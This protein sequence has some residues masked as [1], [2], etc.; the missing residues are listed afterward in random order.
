MESTNLNVNPY[1]DDYDPN[2]N[3]VRTLFRP[4]VAVQARE[5]TQLQTALQAQIERFGDSILKQGSVV[6]GMETYVDNSVQFVKLF[7]TANAVATNVYSFANTNIEGVSSGVQAFVVKVHDGAQANT[8]NLKTL[9]LKY[10]GTGNDGTTRKFV[11]GERIRSSANASLIAN[12]FIG[13]TATGNSSMVTVGNGVFYAHGFFIRVPRQQLIISKYDN[14]AT[15]SIG[16]YI[17]ETIVDADDDATLTDPAQGEYNYTAPGANRLKIEAILTARD[18]DS[19][20][21]SAYFELARVAN[22]TLITNVRPKYSEIR[23]ELARRTYDESGDYTVK[24][25]NVLISEHLNANNN[26]GIFTAAQG[27]NYQKFV[28]GVQPGKAYIR[29]YELETLV[30]DNL[31]LDKGIDTVDLTSQII[32]ANFGNYTYVKRVAGEWDTDNLLTVSLHSTVINATSSLFSSN[33]AA[34]SGVIG[35]ARVRSVQYDSG[36]P[37]GSGQDQYKMFLF[38]IK[39]TGSNKSFADV[40]SLS[41]T[42]GTARGF[43]DCVLSSGR[44]VL[45]DTNFNTGLFPL[46]QNAIRRLRSSNGAINTTIAYRNSSSV[47]ISTGGTFTLTLSGETFNVGAGTLTS[48]QKTT[49]FYVVTTANGTTTLTG[50]IAAAVSNT[51]TGTG[52]LFDRQ[53]RVGDKILFGTNNY[54]RKIT[55]IASNTSLTISPGMTITKSGLTFKRV[56]PKGQV[57][58]YNYT[59]SNPS[60]KV[61][62]IVINSSTSATFDLKETPDAT[63][64]AKVYYTASKTAAREILKTAY[65]SRYIRIKCST[66]GATNVGPWSLGVSDVFSIDEVRKFTTAPASLTGGTVVTSHFDLDNGQR[67][68]VYENARLVK[69]GDSNLSIGASDWLLVKFSFFAPD[70]SQGF[71]YFSVDSYPIDDVHTSNTSAIQTSLIPIYQSPTTGLKYDLRNALDMRPVFTSTANNVTSLTNISTNPANSQTITISTSARVLIPNY[72]IVADLSYYL[73]RIDKIFM[74]TDGQFMVVRGVPSLLPQEPAN[75]AQALPIATV[76]IPPYPS[77]SPAVA[78]QIGNYTYAIQAQAIN[79][80]RFTMKDIASLKARINQLEYYT[81]LTLLELSALDKQFLNNS[82]VD[83]FKNGIFVEQFTGHNKD[84]FLLPEYKASI[85]TL[86]QVMRPQYDIA[87][88]ALDYSAS[89]SSGVVNRASDA[90]LVITGGSG[91]FANGETIS[92]SGGATGTVRYNVNNT[93]LYVEDVTGTFAAAQTLTG[94]TSGASKTISS[95]TLPT[96]SDIFTLPYSHKLLIS[97]PYA[98]KARN[99]AG[100]FYYLFKGSVAITPESDTWYDTNYQPDINTRVE[101]NLAGYTLPNNTITYGDWVTAWV[102]TPTTSQVGAA[103][104]SSDPTSAWAYSLN[105]SQ[106]TEIRQARVNLVG[107]WSIEDVTQLVDDHVI[108]TAVIP[109]MRSQI[110]QIQATALRPNTRHYV[111]FD[112][113]NVNAYVKP[114]NSSF[115]ATGSAGATLTTDDAGSLYALFTIPATDALRFRTGSIKLRLTDGANTASSVTS[116]GE[117]FYT[118]MGSLETRQRTLVTTRQPYYREQQVIEYRTI[119]ETKNFTSAGFGLK[120][121]TTANPTTDINGNPTDYV[122][123]VCPSGADPIAQSFIVKG[124]DGGVFITKI[125][126]FFKNKSSNLPVSVELRE[127][128]NGYPGTKVVSQAVATVFP[129]NV[130]TS[131]NGSLPT[132]FVFPSPVYLLNDVEY[133]FVVKPGANNPD[134]DIWVSE[135]G[136]NDLV[137]GVTIAQQPYT[138]ILFT[139]SNDSTWT[140]QQAE[141]IKFKLYVAEFDTNTTGTLLMKNETANYFNVTNVSSTFSGFE[142]VDGEVRLTL[143]ATSNG[144][145][146]I[147]ASVLGLT[148]RATGILTANTGALGVAGSTYRIR[149]VGANVKF[150]TSER[151]RF[152]SGAIANLTSQTTPKGLAKFYRALPANTQ[153]HL[154]NTTGTFVTGEQL[155]GQVSG[156]KAFISS[157]DNLLM[158]TLFLNI[159]DLK[160]GNTS[161]GYSVKTTNLTA[162]GSTYQTLNNRNNNDFITEEKRVWSKKN[163]VTS[164]SGAKSLTVRGQLSSVNP[165]VSPV[166]D[167]ERASAYVVGNVINNDSTNETNAG[168]GSAKVRYITRQVTLDDGQDAD[169]LK[170]LLTAF[171]PPTSSILVY[172]KILNGQDDTPFDQAPYIL[173]SQTSSSTVYSDSQSPTDVKEYE[174]GFASANLT[175]TNGEVQYTN[176]RGAKFTG[177]KVFALKIVLLNSV[178]YNPPFVKDIRAIALQT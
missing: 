169:D 28:A 106:T 153:I 139:S 5:L 110:I 43:A 113:I 7:N 160:F 49:N 131:D 70:Y 50:T 55:N 75:I 30:T 95:V 94:G 161:L 11:P 34:Y 48:D 127:M 10:T 23:E 108:S 109:Y 66:H 69:K 85:D 90:T 130:N 67:D 44:A 102:G 148:S 59:A 53:L 97:Q 114:A 19:A 87:E 42:N 47:T 25:F 120:N 118:A 140:A 149:D 45:N 157:I 174:Y 36:T 132:P 71:G 177:F 166:V 156:A 76:A 171:K 164:L 122:Q 33:T 3:Y 146:V 14:N 123:G 57:L 112:G 40:R 135:L 88:V 100:E 147:G 16:Y 96:A 117:A 21:T 20:N 46:P 62:S 141:D 152:A 4:G 162:V 86:N 103:I 6:T 27:G 178:T 79:N 104:P 138:G 58:D 60:F 158:N 155:I 63:I 77:V 82:G 15:K 136:S 143:A 64:A 9:Y 84:N 1:Y 165:N 142:E 163:E 13:S 159:A 105:L 125:D 92:S 129:A 137:T 73:L 150:Q 72:N 154:A 12:V 54:V 145:A 74:N 151:I 99:A 68:N 168:G 111:Y 133:C 175:G 31:V 176:T 52:T 32:S 83:R 2:K 89:G 107:T 134:Y 173:L 17:R 51:I 61:R 39:I 167:I 78:K 121:E 172:A 29:G 38:D 37:I 98:T 24:P 26:G 65:K 41:Y 128:I 91:T 93:K 124:Q 8:P 80:Q 101:G 170:V 116:S 144:S 18:I 119:S 22:G 126:L 115:S 81:T 35:T 56:I